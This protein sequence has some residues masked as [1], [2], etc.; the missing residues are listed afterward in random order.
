MAHRF[1]YT[2]R[3]SQE[4]QNPALQKERERDR[5]VLSILSTEACHNVLFY[6]L[7]V[8]KPLIESRTM[9]IIQN[10]PPDK[11]QSEPFHRT[12]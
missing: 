11:G 3:L 12:Q 1:E 4:T 10:F 8:L 6:G 2:D 9:R 5:V 7:S